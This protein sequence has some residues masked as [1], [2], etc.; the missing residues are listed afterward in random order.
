M[1]QLWFLEIIFFSSF[2]FFFVLTAT[3][4]KA[5][6]RPY[7]DVCMIQPTVFESVNASRWAAE[8]FRLLR[9]WP[10]IPETEFNFQ[11]Q[12]LTPSLPM[13]H[14]QGAMAMVN[15]SLMGLA[16]VAGVTATQMDQSGLKS[17][18]TSLTN[19]TLS[20]AFPEVSMWVWHPSARRGW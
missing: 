16:S 8:V 17:A 15:K 19:W 5:F 4:P 2:S 9:T 18:L 7:C 6:F 11:E 13:P 12:K 1:M 14:L 20:M 10:T 3:K